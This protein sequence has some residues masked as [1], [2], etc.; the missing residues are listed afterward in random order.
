MLRYA[1]LTHA[2]RC[3][4]ASLAGV[5]KHLIGKVSVVD[6]LLMNAP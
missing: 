2:C 4:R 3:F 1:G 5:A 6:P